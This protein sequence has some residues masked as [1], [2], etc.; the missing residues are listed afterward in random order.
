MSDLFASTKWLEAAP[1]K[2]QKANMSR[3]DLIE[4]ACEKDDCVCES[5]CLACAN[6]VLVSNG[7]H[8]FVFTDRVR[9]LLSKGRAKLPNCGK[10]FLLDPIEIIFKT[11]SSPAN[12]KYGWVGANKAEVVFLNDF[13][14]SSELIKWNEFSLIL[15]GHTVRFPAPKNHF[16]SDITSFC[17]Y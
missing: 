4:K 8:L 5:Q 14:S 11:F 2:F 15:E 16:A 10:T 1:E 12:D 9:T 13:R 7:V 3:M 6:Q 17:Y